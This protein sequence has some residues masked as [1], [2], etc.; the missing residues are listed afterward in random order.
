MPIATVII[1]AYNAERYV[2]RAI[3][4]ILAQTLQDFELLIVDDGS[5]D[6][7]LEVIRRYHDP[8]IKVIAQPNSGKAVAI[9]RLLEFARGEFLA[10][11][12]ADDW[13]APERLEVLT[14][15]MR[16]D[17]RLGMVF[18]GYALVL[19]DRICAPRR[20]QAN[21]AQCQM[22]I[23]NYLTPGLDPTMMV[24]TDIA[25]RTRFDPALRIGQGLDFIL[26]VGEQYA[27]R[28]L[29][30]ILYYYRFHSE[31]ITKKDPSKKTPYLLQVL[32]SARVRRGLSPLPM[33]TFL[34][35][36]GRYLNDSN[37]NLSGHFTDA[38]YWSVTSGRRLEAARTAMW[39]LKYVP[40]GGLSYAKPLVY[41]LAPRFI[42]R[43]V[44][45]K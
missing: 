27:S 8:R 17:P 3:E 39:S 28:L 14:K 40:R 20:S 12:D 30:D 16:E 9:N 42:A 29:P 41:A 33:E 1:S 18:S 22:R 6:R 11:Q 19:D 2:G 15:A 44:R 37:N 23:D 10:L 21:E 43:M 24:R 13:S 5:T 34:Q 36:N 25:R 26:K 45:R 4:S 32:N 35:D 31:S 38:A 7:T